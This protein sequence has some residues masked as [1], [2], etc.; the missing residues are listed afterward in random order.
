MMQMRPAMTAT[1][2]ALIAAQA[3]AQPLPPLPRH[4]RPYAAVRAE[5]ART[6]YRPVRFRHG[7]DWSGCRRS[8]SSASS[9]VVRS[10]AR[11][12]R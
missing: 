7:A 3:L 6:G 10:M 9:S 1:L 8:W 5:L 12:L 2:A 11:P 4:H